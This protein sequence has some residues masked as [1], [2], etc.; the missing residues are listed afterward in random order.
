MELDIIL[1][2]MQPE[3]SNYTIFKAL[4]YCFPFVL[5]HFIGNMQINGETMTDFVQ[6][7]CLINRFDKDIFC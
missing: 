6:A 7:A 5:A 1:M 4:S 2:K 3:V